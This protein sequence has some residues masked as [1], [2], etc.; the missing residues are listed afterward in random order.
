MEFRSGYLATMIGI[1]TGAHM[2]PQWTFPLVQASPGAGVATAPSASLHY[3]PMGDFGAKRDAASALNASR[4][5][6]GHCS[7]WRVVFH[8]SLRPLAR[9]SDSCPAHPG[10]RRADA[11]SRFVCDLEDLRWVN[12]WTVA[13]FEFA[14]GVHRGFCPECGTRL[15]NRYDFAFTSVLC[16]GNSRGG[17]AVPDNPEEIVITVES[18]QP[19]FEIE[20]DV[21]LF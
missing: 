14:P 9:R 18:R 4:V 10:R 11:R 16:D 12:G 17:V 21:V 5:M 1:T 3:S 7:C 15:L 19:W 8:A 6:R 2:K 13:W 20:D